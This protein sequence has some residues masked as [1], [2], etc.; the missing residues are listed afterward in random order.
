MNTSVTSVSSRNAL[1]RWI[2]AIFTWIERIQRKGFLV[3]VAVQFLVLCG[4]ILMQI[5]PHMSGNTVWLKVVPVDPRDMFRGDYVILSYEMSRA[6]ADF[7]VQSDEIVAVDADGVVQPAPPDLPETGTAVYVTL[8]LDADGVHH[9]ADQF[10]TEPP[11]SGPYIRGTLQGGGRIEYG[12]ESFYVQAGTG[13]EYE[14]AARTGTLSAEVA[15]SPDGQAGLNQL[16][17]N[18][19]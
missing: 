8:V 4:M 2:D 6:P 1:S 9:R 14:Q 12:I 5:I 13:L 11:A 18:K 19:H 17:V 15:I 3:A 16:Q 10:L 7:A